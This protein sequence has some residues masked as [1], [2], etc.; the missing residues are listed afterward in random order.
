MDRDTRI[1]EIEARL[2]AKLMGPNFHSEDKEIDLRYLLAEVN[3]L[4]AEWER[5][6]KRT[7]VQVD[8]LVAENKRLRKALEVISNMQPWKVGKEEIISRRAIDVARKALE[9]E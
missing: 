1:A 8:E 6:R 3:R 4:E 5:D 2:H 9:G 7:I